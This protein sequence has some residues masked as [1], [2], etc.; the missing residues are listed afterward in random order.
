MADDRDPNRPTENEVPGTN[1]PAE[2]D[3]S[4][5]FMTREEV[6]PHKL[7]GKYDVISDIKMGHAKIP[8]FLK[9]TYGVLAAWGLFYMV[10]AQPV[11]DRTE[12][13]PTAE[14]TVEAGADVF[15]TS[16]AGCHAVT[17]DRKI[18]PGMAGV[19]ERLGAEELEK[20]LH[21]GRPDKGMPAPPSLGINENDIKSLQLYLETLK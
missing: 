7:D 3:L 1:K 12:A 18:G 2:T 9:I 15:A 13:A 10:T 16:C 19:A 17:T 6:E 21:Q 11:N 20:V 4:E 5:E 14:P 8:T